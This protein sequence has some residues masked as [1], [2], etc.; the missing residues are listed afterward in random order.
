MKYKLTV[1]I[2]KNIDISDTNITKFITEIEE[3]FEI[4]E[5]E[6][7]FFNKIPIEE[8]NPNI[9]NCFL[10]YI[11]NTN[12]NIFEK[13]I[14]D[15]L[16]TFNFIENYTLVI[17]N[18]VAKSKEMVQVTLTQIS[19]LVNDIDKLFYIRCSLQDIAEHLPDNERQKY[20]KLLKELSLTK[21]HLK[22]SAFNLRVTNLFFE[23]SKIETRLLEYA[24][25]F[26]IELNFKYDIKDIKLD[27]LI[28]Y[29]LKPVLVDFLYTIIN[30]EIDKRDKLIKYETLDIDVKF[31]QDFNK[32]RVYIYSNHI[33]DNKIYSR[34]FTDDFIELSTNEE[35]REQELIL[36]NVYK[37]IKDLGKIKLV[38]DNTLIFSIKLD[39]L[40]L[41]ALIIRNDMGY[42]AID[43]NLVKE[44][45]DF[46][47]EKIV[48]INNILYY[49]KNGIHL[50]ILN[51]CKNTKNIITVKIKNQNF[52]FLTKEVLYEEEIYVRPFKNYSKEYIGDCLL[53]DTKKALVVNL[54]SYI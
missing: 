9:L 44:I 40:M 19:N 11:I 32:L 34:I 3:K 23:F 15:F 29:K 13:M 41:E 45:S 26:G 22:S 38:E 51:E 14:K 49:N 31:K 30:N 54:K 33:S 50:P 27:K 52:A 43:T 4:L 5:K 1:H 21:Y 2:K 37:S 12:D 48:N 16:A 25:S 7:K 36:L 20:T 10:E 47:K 18:E 39:F 53:K 42:Y 6:C 17:K 28:Y 35:Q 46:N 8:Y 24:K